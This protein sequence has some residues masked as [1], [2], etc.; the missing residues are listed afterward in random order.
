MLRAILTLLGFQLAGETLARLSSL[1]VPGPVIGMA[2]LFAILSA[3]PVG[4]SRALDRA[5]SGLLRHF[6]LLFVPAG[7]GVVT[8]LDRLLDEVVPI[9]LSLVISV[10]FVVAATAT[11]MRGLVRHAEDS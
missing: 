9:G 3:R 1:P 4:E 6:S 5:A 8:H 2:M 10:A 7:V 11:S